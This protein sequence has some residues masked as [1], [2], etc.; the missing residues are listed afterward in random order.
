MLGRKLRKN[1]SKKVN[2]LN[3]ALLIFTVIMMSVLILGL[4]HNHA[5]RISTTTLHLNYPNDIRY[6]VIDGPHKGRWGH[7][8]STWLGLKVRLNVKRTER[9][10]YDLWHERKTQDKYGWDWHSHLQFIGRSHITVWRWQVKK[11]EVTQ[12]FKDRD[13]IRWIKFI[14]RLHRRKG[15]PDNVMIINGIEHLYYERKR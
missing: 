13:N 5:Y 3:I 15:K 11:I 12:D 14:N 4:F 7:A 6:E 10:I 2:K 1:W 8:W 9:E